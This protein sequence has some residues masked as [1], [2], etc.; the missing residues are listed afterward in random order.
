MV[1]SSPRAECPPPERS[2]QSAIGQLG[3]LALSGPGEGQRRGFDRKPLHSRRVSLSTPRLTDV[4]HDAPVVC[5]GPTLPLLLFSAADFFF[6]QI[7][8]NLKRGQGLRTLFSFRLL[9]K[10]SRPLN[11]LLLISKV[12]FF[13][14]PANFRHS[15]VCHK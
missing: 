11:V 8:K 2:R 7:N 13:K 5:Y 12:N 14:K 15:N 4:T 3:V 1:P 10:F 6:F 9:V